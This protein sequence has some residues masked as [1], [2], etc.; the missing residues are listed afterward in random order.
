MTHEAHNKE[1]IKRMKL[2]IQH[3][4]R[5]RKKLKENDLWLIAG[6]DALKEPTDEAQQGPMINKLYD[7][8]D[9][10]KKFLREKKW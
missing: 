10:N 2:L 7:L 3:I 9:E 4:T 8:I 5:M 6:F 1:L